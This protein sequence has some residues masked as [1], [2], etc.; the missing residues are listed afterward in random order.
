MEKYEILI[1]GAGVGGYTAA[2]RLAQYGKKV[3][4]VEKEEAGGVCLN[5]GCIPTKALLHA[6]SMYKLG[7]SGSTRSG[8]E[9]KGAN[10]NLDKLRK[11]RYSV[12]MRLSKG[13]LFLFKQ[14]GIEFIKG[15]ARVI[16]KN[17]I[18]VDGRTIYGERIILATGSSPFIPSSMNISEYWT[19]YEALDVPE[20]PESLLIVG[21]GVIGVELATIYTLLGAKVTIVEI[22]NDILP[23]MDRDLRQIKRKE[24]KKL[25]VKIL[26][27][28][29]LISYKD[30]TAY[31]D[32]EE[33]VEKISVSRIMVASG[34]IPNTF[35][36]DK[37]GIERDGKY[38]KVKENYETSLNGV[39]A[40][41]DLVKGPML[42]HRA[43][44]DG[45]KVADAIMGNFEK[46][47]MFV[48]SVVY[49]EISL[50][51]IGFT[52][53]ELVDRNVTYQKG[54]FP[55]AANGRS[56]TMESNE[57]FCKILG[58]RDTGRIYGIH[59]AGVGVDEL[60]GEVS[61][62]M[63]NGLKV[64]D[65]AR[66]IHAHP[67]LGESIMEA[68]EHFYRRAIHIPNK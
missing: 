67:T 37:L 62:A 20:I 13:L 38:V 48:P 45:I 42:A 15:E 10:L 51:S 23:F 26:T 9:F 4:I 39:Y 36:A 41:G 6:A 1:I 61:L 12:S 52:E 50:V 43:H 21:G 49:G 60:A 5:K 55:L 33:K 30:G 53:D 46:G 47:E 11:W 58:D 34:R 44:F 8:I 65:I 64:E 35:L 68:A 59:I 29:K 14:Y 25:G 32:T 17:T 56:L 40:I 18:E 27:G 54:H 24:L 2:I 28:S 3:A 16:D 19:S 63:N 22:M 31:I 66:T 57:G 7:N